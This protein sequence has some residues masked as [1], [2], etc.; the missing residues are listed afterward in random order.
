MRVNPRDPFFSG[1]ASSGSSTPAH[2][3]ETGHASGAVAS[4]SSSSGRIRKVIY[5]QDHRGPLSTDT[6][7]TLM[8]LQADNVEI[9]GITTVAGDGT[10]GLTRMLRMTGK[11]S[12]PIPS[13]LFS[14]VSRSGRRAK[15]SDPP[16]TSRQPPDCR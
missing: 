13:P 6:V 11:V 1:L 16:G 5:D 8:L 3:P 4:Q 12:V 7:G 10:V 14:T 9:L 2:A 15:M